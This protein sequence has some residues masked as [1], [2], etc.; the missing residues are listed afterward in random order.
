MEP[1]ISEAK[2]KEIQTMIKLIDEYPI[3]G[4]VNME[5]LPAKQLQ[6]MREK[7]RET[8]LIR[9]SKVRLIRLALK[10]AKKDNVSKLVEY[11]PD[12][13]KVLFQQIDHSEIQSLVEKYIDYGFDLN[14][15]SNLIEYIET[16]KTN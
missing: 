8:V 12:C 1:H 5:N 3:V 16:I 6:I 7:L 15:I 14:K 10:D 4:I 9:M 11:D 13:K 2:K